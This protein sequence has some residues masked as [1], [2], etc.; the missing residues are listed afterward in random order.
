VDVLDAGD[1][2]IG[3]EQDRLEG[4]LA[5]AEVEEVFQAGAEQI[6]NHGVVVALGAEPADKGDT[7]AASEGFVDACFIFELGM[8]GF[9]A[10]ELDGDFLAGDDVGAFKVISTR[11]RD[12]RCTEVGYVPR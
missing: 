12:K 8:L 2:L 7:D 5:V 11:Q 9:D 10:L 4:E 1:E 3:E 6:E